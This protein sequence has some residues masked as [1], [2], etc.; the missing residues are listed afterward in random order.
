ML[1]RDLQRERVYMDIRTWIQDHTA[2][3]PSGEEI[4]LPL[5][6]QSVAATSASEDVA[7]SANSGH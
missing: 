7:S 1:L 4:P 3:L 2:P 5:R 6:G